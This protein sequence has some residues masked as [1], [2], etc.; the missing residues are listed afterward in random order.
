MMSIL[1]STENAIVLDI[2]N[3]IH[4]VSRSSCVSFPIYIVLNVDICFLKSFAD[5]YIHNTK[6]ITHHQTSI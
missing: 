3:L 4:D 1:R 6:I 5:V 2:Y